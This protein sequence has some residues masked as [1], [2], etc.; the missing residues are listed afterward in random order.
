MPHKESITLVTVSAHAPHQTP[1]TLFSARLFLICLALLSAG[2]LPACGSALRP[3]APQS[4]SAR[5]SPV[6]QD[7]KTPSLSSEQLNQLASAQVVLIGETHD[8][9][10]HHRVQADVIRELKPK[11][12]AFEMLDARHQPLLDRLYELPPD[13]WDQALD[14]TKRGWPDFELYRPVFEAAL[15]V[16]AKLLA[17][18][19]TPKTLH[20]LKL[21]GDLDKPLRDRLKLDVPLPDSERAALAEIIRESHCGYAN[22]QMTEAMIKAQRLKDAWMG[23]ALI[24]STHPVIL[25]V[26]RGHVHPK[27]GIPW[28]VKLLSPEAPQV[29]TIELSPSAQQDNQTLDHNARLNVVK[30]QIKPHRRDDP[31]ERFREQLKQMKRAHQ[32]VKQSKDAPSED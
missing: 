18:H 27:R 24:S 23:E 32:R 3:S 22:A 21:G 31:C 7:Q 17:A 5:P 9:P 25:I 19:P 28:A 6:N 13:T 16:K 1:Y 8:H 11:T 29:A 20:P 10:T 12:V 2:I 30:L 15:E 14:W 4:E 26:G